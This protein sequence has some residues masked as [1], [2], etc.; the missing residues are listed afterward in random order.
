VRSRA[1]SA[2][3][4]DGLDFDDL[5][6]PGDEGELMHDS[7]W[8]STIWKPTRDALELPGFTT[9]HLRNFGARQF[10]EAG[11]TIED[12]RK[13]LG[14]QDIETTARYLTT[15]DDRLSSLTERV[16]ESRRESLRRRSVAGDVSR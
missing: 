7:T 13:L 2:D 14:H 9:R 15:D 6:F 10:L 4:I 1:S 3:S 11:A 5:I 8:H 16:G 12:L